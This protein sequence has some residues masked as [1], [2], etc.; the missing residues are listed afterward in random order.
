MRGIS[1][2]KLYKIFIFSVIV[3]ISLPY[4]VEVLKLF[5]EICLIVD[6]VKV[7]Y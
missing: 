4:R 1:V 6:K 5:G 7:D 2:I 3:R